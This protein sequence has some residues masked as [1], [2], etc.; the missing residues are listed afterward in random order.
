MTGLFFI[1]TVTFFILWLTKKPGSGEA[2]EYRHGYWE[3]YRAFGDKVKNALKRGEISSKTLQTFIDAGYPN[4]A[5]DGAQTESETP[6]EDG[7]QEIPVWA[8][9]SPAYQEARPITVAKRDHTTR[10]MNTVLYVASFLFVAAAAAFVAASMPDVVRLAGLW[11]V[12]LAFYGTGLILYVSVERLRPAALAFVGTGLAILPFAGYALYL[13]GDVSATT[14]WLITSIIG[15]GAYAAATWVLRSQV[16]AYLTMALVVSL[17]LSSTASLGAPVVWYFVVLIALSLLMNIIGFLKPS[18]WLGGIFSKPLEVTGHILVPLTLLASL[19]VASNTTL[20]TYEIVFGLATAH[21]AVLWLRQK[22]M[23]FETAVRILLHAT[24]LLIGWDIVNGEWPGLAAWWAIAAT[25]QALY[26]IIRFKHETNAGEVVWLALMLTGLMK[27]VI[28]WFPG[29]HAALGAL[30]N[31]AAIVLLGTWAAYRWKQMTW[32]IIAIVTSVFIP[33]VV[34]RWLM[35][36]LWEWQS[37]AWLFA[38]ASTVSLGLLY[39]VKAR[40]IMRTRL[41]TLLKV[42]FWIYAAVAFL[43]AIIAMEN[44]TIASLSLVLALL[45]LVYSYVVRAETLQ[46]LASGLII[47]AVMAGGYEYIADGRWRI[48]NNVLILAVFF[49]ALAFLQYRLRQLYR[50]QISVLFGLLSF[51]GLIFTLGSGGV[52][53]IP[54]MLLL[55]VGSTLSLLVRS[56]L[57]SGLALLKTSLGVFYPTFLGIAW[58]LSFGQEAGWNFIFYAVTATVLCVVSYI[59]RQPWVGIISNLAVL[60]ATGF[61]WVWLG[62]PLIWA[63]IGTTII[64][65]LVFYGSYLWALWKHDSWRQWLHLISLWVV[66]GLVGVSQMYSASSP[67]NGVAALIFT[68]TALTLVAHGYIRHHRTMVEVGVYIVTYGLQQF[69]AIAAPEFSV[70]FYAHW[71]A[72]VIACAA[73]LRRDEVNEGFTTRLVVA[74]AIISSVTGLWALGEG[75]GYQLLFLVEHAALLVAGGLLQKSWAVWWGAVGSILSVVYFLK[76]YPYVALAFLGLVLVG[77]VVWRLMR[78]SRGSH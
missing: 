10:N 57:L 65:S 77:I 6:V 13:L 28:L 16:V 17:S 45:V 68:A 22:R 2:E 67:Y 29:E 56:R 46:A 14:A 63:T 71:W 54:G 24:V 51:V 38:G 1:L 30:F 26:S 25:M 44:V 49:Y 19:F 21:Y 59:E 55:L 5:K 3:G 75:G 58:L 20:F 50:F 39:A 43:V 40:Q 4:P 7:G 41:A 73:W 62:L 48:I 33:F 53:S 72:A 15:V 11:L 12:T 76:E 66:A 47:V 69:T 52:V 64:V 36:P 74:M 61:A 70:V 37:I 78:T 32:A 27:G 23:I 31:L 9:E 35:E 34:G 18:S 42:A 60:M 8:K